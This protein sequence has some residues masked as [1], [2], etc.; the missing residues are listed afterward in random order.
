MKTSLHL[1]ISGLVCVGRLM[2]RNIWFFAKLMV[3]GKDEI[4]VSLILATFK[5]TSLQFRAHPPGQ[6]FIGEG[7]YSMFSQS[8]HIYLAFQLSLFLLRY[9]DLHIFFDYQY[10]QNNA[11]YFVCHC[12][13]FPPISYE[14]FS[15]LLLRSTACY[16]LLCNLSNFALI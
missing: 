13:C 14:F 11:S 1:N 10:S 3:Q 4:T 15:T 2:T 8:F 7:I 6:Y 9:S 16:L 5:N 12:S